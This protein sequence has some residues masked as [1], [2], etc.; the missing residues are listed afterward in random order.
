MTITRE[1]SA[2]FLITAAVASTGTSWADGPTRASAGEFSGTY[3]YRSD[4]GRFATWSVTPCGPGCADVA[5]TPVTD[6]RITPY[7][8]Q[9]RLVDGQ[10]YMIV[11]TAQAVRC[12]PPNDNT[13]VPGTVE[14]WF[15]T[16]SLSGTAL[17]TQAV[18]G[19]GDPAG[20]IY[21]GTFTLSRV[22]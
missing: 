4:S 9:A 7:G 12:N 13:T 21:E 15:D 10:W 19:C 1:L 20:A 11:Q 16:A 22:S 14:F 2:A 18:D 5:V 8:G 17:N 3:S 6:P